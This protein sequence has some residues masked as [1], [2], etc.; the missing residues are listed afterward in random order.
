MTLD[1]LRDSIDDYV[2]LS[3]YEGLEVDP[4]DYDEDE[5]DDYSA[6]MYSE[7]DIKACAT[8]LERF[9]DEL[10]DNEGDEEAIKKAVKTLSLKLNK[11]NDR[12]EHTLIDS[13]QSDGICEFVLDAVNAAGLDIDEDLTE[14]WRSW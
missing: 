4:D 11:L 9:V 13:D 10:E 3:M 14:Q 2:I 8:L 6:D 7:R 1:E 5:D 12:T